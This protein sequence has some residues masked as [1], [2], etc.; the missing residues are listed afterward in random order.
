MNKKNSIQINISLL[1]Q[2]DLNKIRFPINFE[3]YLY[4]EY[5]K[6]IPFII[7]KSNFVY[8]S[9]FDN[10]NLFNCLCKKWDIKKRDDIITN[11]ISIIYNLPNFVET[12]YNCVTNHQ[13]LYIPGEF[14][15]SNQY[16]VNDFLLNN[17]NSLFKI[18]TNYFPNEPFCY[19]IITD[20]NYL[21]LFP[22]KLE[23]MKQWASIFYIG[24]IFEI[25][26]FKIL[27]K[28]KIENEQNENDNLIENEITF[29][30]INKSYVK[31]KKFSYTITTNE[32]NFSEINSIINEKNNKIETNISMIIPNYIKENEY[33]IEKEDMESMKELVN[34]IKSFYKLKKENNIFCSQVLIELFKFI[35]ALLKENGDEEGSKYYEDKK[36]K[37]E[38]I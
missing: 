37:Y 13:L 4:P 7:C 25:E 35:S 33:K 6:K 19:F 11:L 28:N 5:A 10:R 38:I 12:Y 27:S 14:S 26:N 20:I 29:E 21:L 9:I 17:D 15:I 2:T 3:I 34:E 31:N 22:S 1:K 36:K 23:N 30:I 24:L 18:K 8:P 32:N 16:N